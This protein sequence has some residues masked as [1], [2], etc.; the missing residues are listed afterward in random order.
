MKEITKIEGKPVCEDCHTVMFQKTIQ[1]SGI[2]KN[3]SGWSCPECFTT[4]WVLD[5]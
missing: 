2:D 5:E 4:R 1:T 3:I